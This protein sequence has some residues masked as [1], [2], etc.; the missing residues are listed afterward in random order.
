[1]RAVLTTAEPSL[2]TSQGNIYN[3][4]SRIVSKVKW[5]TSKLEDIFTDVHSTLSEP[6]KWKKYSKYNDNLIMLE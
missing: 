3:M 2:L 6:I 4:S 5:R 1:M